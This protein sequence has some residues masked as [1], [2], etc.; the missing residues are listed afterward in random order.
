MAVQQSGI[1]SAVQGLAVELLPLTA[2][3]TQGMADHLYAGILELS[4]SE[5]EELPR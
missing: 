4:A 2:E 5:D 1:A 3:R